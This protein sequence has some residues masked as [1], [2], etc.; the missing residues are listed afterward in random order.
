MVSRRSRAL[1]LPAGKLRGTPKRSRPHH[2]AHPGRAELDG[3][4]VDAIVLLTARTPTSTIP[5]PDGKAVVTLKDAARFFQD[6]TR[7]PPRFSKTS[8]PSIL[9]LHA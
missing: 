6:A 5:R 9:I 7:I 3:V 2:Q 1:P 4:Y 8:S